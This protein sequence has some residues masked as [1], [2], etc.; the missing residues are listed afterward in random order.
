MQKFLSTY[1]KGDKIIW[2]LVIMMMLISA[3]TMYSASS[4]LAHRAV[5]RGGYYYGPVWSHVLFLLGGL[6]VVF[7]VHRIP[8]RFII[9]L[10]KPLYFLSIIFLILTPLIGVEVNGA[11]RWL[12][13]GPIAFQPSEI[14]K[15]FTILYL[16]S[17]LAKYQN[18]KNVT[19]DDGLMKYLLILG[20]PSVIIATE[21]LSTFLLLMMIGFM[22]M[23]YARLSFKLILKMVGVG[24]LAVALGVGA[25]MLIPEE[26]SPTVTSAA[27]EQLSTAKPRGVFHRAL[28]WKHRLMRHFEAEQPHDAN[29]KLNDQ[30]YQE[31]RAKIAVASGKWF[32]LG[33][34]NSIQRDFLPLAYADF[35]FSLMVE[36]VGVFALF[37]LLLY[38]IFMYRVGVLIRQYCNSVVQSL[39]VLG[40]SSMIMVQTY[41]NVFIAMGLFPVSG[42]PLPLFSRGGTSILITCLYFGIILCVSNESMSQQ[43]AKKEEKPDAPK[44]K[45][46]KEEPL[47]LDAQPA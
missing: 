20:V 5:A 31:D 8:F 33:I 43:A 17:T 41:I 15:I 6:I 10:S 46:M 39:V 9:G 14:A 21:N 2:G 22:M 26:S 4:S 12:Q 35:I 25:L 27:T 19:P 18:Q 3:F 38:L 28:T 44:K 47:E 16:A 32:G 29:Y 24:V 34:G 23:F 11:K 36:E 13:L 30:T 1:I 7:L 45:E 42:Q 40:L 37:I